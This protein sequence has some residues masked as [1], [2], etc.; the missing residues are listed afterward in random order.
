M[1][2][3]LLLML[4]LYSPGIAAQD[5]TGTWEGD[6]VVGI[7]GQM[8]HISKIRF[9]LVQLERELKGI[10]TRYPE[11][12]KPGD[13]PNVVY[14]VS[15]CMGKKKPIPFLLIKGRS[16]EGFNGDGVFQFIINY[17][18]KDSVEY[19][20]GKWFSSLEP[21]G[22]L[23]RGRGVYQLQCVSHTVSEKL[24][25]DYKQKIIIEKHTKDAAKSGG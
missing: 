7:D 13:D 16:I 14:T 15:G 6:I 24:E 25:P 18:Q 4:C 17:K 10:V 2:N 1:R 20:G 3:L 8:K 19:I 11:D 22:T 9:E 23:E 21:L 12:T 5:L